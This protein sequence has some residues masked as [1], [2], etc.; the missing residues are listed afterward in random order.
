MI[1]LKVAYVERL[2]YFIHMKKIVDELHPPNVSNIGQSWDKIANYPPNAQYKSA[3]L[4]NAST[5]CCVYKCVCVLSYLLV[6][7]YPLSTSAV[8]LFFAVE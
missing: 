7:Q 1:R 3:L 8:L 6:N 2:S 5:K 4:Q